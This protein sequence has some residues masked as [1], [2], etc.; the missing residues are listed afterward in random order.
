MHV[1][2]DVGKTY[3]VA[4]LRV[5]LRIFAIHTNNNVGAYTGPNVCY[6]TCHSAPCSFK[7][8]WVWTQLDHWRDG[9]AEQI[10]FSCNSTIVLLPIAPVPPRSGEGQ[11]GLRGHPG[12][13][14][15]LVQS[16]ADRPTFV[17][18]SGYPALET[19]LV[20][21]LLFTPLINK[22][23]IYFLIILAASA[24]SPLH[25]SLI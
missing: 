9:G 15:P 1:S 19:F 3:V 18:S 20:G 2:Q 5:F 14:R 10:E 6:V 12:P 22:K 23:A 25:L 8:S 11:L 13:P 21:P 17:V 7:C 16:T 4:V 24:S